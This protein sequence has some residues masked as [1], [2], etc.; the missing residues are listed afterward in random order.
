MTI[1]AIIE[2]IIRVP[3]YYVPPC[4]IC[5]GWMTGRYIK[6]HRNVENEWAV[7]EALKNG[8]LVKPV[9]HLPDDRDCICYI[10]NISFDGPSKLKFISLRERN[11]ERQRRNTDT[12][13]ESIR[14]QTFSEPP[15]KKLFGLV[16]R[17]VGKI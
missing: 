9:M 14:G 15:K 2:K 1:K 16:G 12:I 11:E 10:C 6:M 3:Y 17:F 7:K 5:G 8:E 4:P 13:L